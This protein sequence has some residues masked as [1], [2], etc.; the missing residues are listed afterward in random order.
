MSVA[1]DL[2]R[3]S[4]PLDAASFDTFYR[5]HRG[6]VFRYVLRDVGNRADAE[7]VTQT[8]FLDAYRALRRGHAPEL[9]RAWMYGIA[10]N[11]T[12]R[13][14]RMLSR[15]PR[16]VELAPEL[17]ET[18]ASEP[19]D[20]LPA[21]RAAV[22]DLRPNYREAVFLRE[23]EG[24]TYAEIAE[25]MNLS[26]AA[27]E[28]LLFRARRALRD[29]L[30]A[31]GII[32]A[33]RR[34]LR[35]ARGAIL[36]PVGLWRGAGRLAD[37]LQ[38]DVAVKAAAGAA[39]VAM[40]AGIA[41]GTGVLP[42]RAA[43]VLPR[44][45]MSA[46][47]QTPDR[48]AARVT[49]ATAQPTGLPAQDGKGDRR[50][51]SDSKHHPSSASDTTGSA[52]GA[53]SDGASGTSGDNSVPASADGSSGGTAAA[54]VETPSLETPAVETPA[55]ETPSAT[56][57]ST[58]TTLP[59]G[60]GGTDVTTPEVDVPSVTVPSVTV[61]SETVDDAVDEVGGLVGGTG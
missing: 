58:T 23:V 60:D 19:D 48:P 7:E 41:V 16:E 18:L 46:P 4:S 5:D 51:D 53:S 26:Q 59:V 56:V 29:R 45:D 36:A 52:G 14:Y 35:R 38:A 32:P 25:R 1:T 40:G 44:Q 27:V 12:R 17:E 37:L 6:E 50:R 24:L 21:I 55:V 10:R 49:L 15:R 11:A 47:A 42:V 13:R 20:E 2:G 33:V 39:V 54:T 57:P 28:T 34:G 30:E 31:E 61:P 9:P 43:P 8:A 3:E 22:A